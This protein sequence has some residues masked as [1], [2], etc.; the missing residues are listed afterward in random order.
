MYM[1]VCVYIYIYREREI[2]ILLLLSL[3]SLSLLLSW[4]HNIAIATIAS[5]RGARRR[6]TPRSTSCIRIYHSIVP[7]WFYLY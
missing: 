5:S 6:G 3:V 2:L 1:Y 7:Y 4:A